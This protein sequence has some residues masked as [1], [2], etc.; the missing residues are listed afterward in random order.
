MTAIGCDECGHLACVCQILSDHIDGCRFRLAAT[1]PVPI[2]CE[3][4]RDCCPECD[5]CTCAAVIALDD[6]WGVPQYDPGL[7]ERPEE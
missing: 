6:H 5:P 7:D 3:H 2:E 4:G 1:C